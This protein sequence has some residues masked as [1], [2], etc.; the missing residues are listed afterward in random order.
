[1]INEFNGPSAGNCVEEALS[2]GICEIVERHVSSLVSQQKISVP[3]INPDSATDP[4][5]KEM[6]SKYKANNIQLFLSDFLRTV[7]KTHVIWLQ[8]IYCKNILRNE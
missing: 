2:Q 8:V 6:L 1:M 3:I 4:L 7:K 5:V